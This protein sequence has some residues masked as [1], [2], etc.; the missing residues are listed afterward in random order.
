MNNNSKYLLKNQR[1]RDRYANDIEFRNKQKQLVKNY[2]RNHPEKMKNDRDLAKKKW[3]NFISKY[4]QTG[5]SKCGYNKCLQGLEFHHVEPKNKLFNVSFGVWRRIGREKA[6]I[7]FLEEMEK[8]V[9]LCANCHR[10]LEY[11]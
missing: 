8:C 10:E 7:L 1:F 11:A 4:K 5:C 6:T 9:L 3:V 2:Q